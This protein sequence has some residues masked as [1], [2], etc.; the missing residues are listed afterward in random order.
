M[1]AGRSSEAIEILSRALLA[2]RECG[3]S[4]GRAAARLWLSLAYLDLHQGEHFASGVEDLLALCETHGY[5]FLFT[6]P[7]LLGPPDPRRLVPLLLEA[8]ARKRRPAYAARLLADLGLPDIQ[9]HPGYQLRLQTL[10]AFRAWRGDVE[11]EPREWRRDKARQLF[12]LFITQRDRQF[13]R[14]EITEILWPDLSPEAAIRDFKVAL[15]ALN[16]VLEPNR[17]ADAPFAFIVREG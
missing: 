1:L 4:F 9:M 17:P 7:T 8:R 15:N 11:I 10:G 13:Q 2:F 16:K 14:E 3:D 12:Q 5:H 6:A